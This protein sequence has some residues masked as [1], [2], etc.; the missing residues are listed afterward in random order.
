MRVIK[1]A[2]GLMAKGIKRGDRVGLLEHPCPQFIELYIA[3][4]RIG[5]VLV[6]LNCRLSGCELEYII[7]DADVKML[8]MGEEFTDVI[9]EI[10]SDLKTVDSYYCIGKAP[11]E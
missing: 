8:L 5:A 9:N 7:N 4:P 2:N 3:I 1:L 10:K 6:P 11:K